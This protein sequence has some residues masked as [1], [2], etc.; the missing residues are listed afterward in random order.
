MNI[1]LIYN[2]I[3]MTILRLFNITEQQQQTRKWDMTAELNHID[4]LQFH[5]FK[6]SQVTAQVGKIF[7][8]LSQ[9]YVFNSSTFATK[10]T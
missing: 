4:F 5:Y 2:K 9:L 7:F 10:A 3:K 8:I 1:N 6:K